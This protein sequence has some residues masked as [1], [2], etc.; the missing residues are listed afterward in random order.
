LLAKAHEWLGQ[1]T[2]GRSRSISS[3][4]QAQRVTSSYVTRVVQLAV[5]A[6][7]IVQRIAHGEQPPQLTARQLIHAVPLPLDWAQQ[8]A[9]LGFGP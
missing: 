4:A 9:L 8:R 7:D 3:I 1:L 5:L 6:P 2:S